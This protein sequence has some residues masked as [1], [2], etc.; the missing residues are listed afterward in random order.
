GRQRRGGQHHRDA[1]TGGDP[2]GFDLGLHPA[3]ADPGTAGPADAY[4]GEVVGAVDLGDQGRRPGGG[5]GVVE[6]VDVGEED[7]QVGA[8]QVRH[9][10][11]EPVVVP[12][13]D[14]GRGDGVVLV[15]HRH[16][17]EVEQRLE[18][19][20]GVAVVAAAGDVVDG[21]QHLTGDQAVAGQR[22]GVAVD[23]QPLA[24]RRRGLLP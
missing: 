1:G 24:D 15:D 11:T 9:Q 17:P 22:L 2:G 16:D 12:E 14:L 13:P 23:E 21:E 8:D 10:R 19:T 20:A 6:T 4:A 5:V 7:E 3:R 18:R